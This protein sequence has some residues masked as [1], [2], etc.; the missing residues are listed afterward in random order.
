MKYSRL[1]LYYVKNEYID[2]L[3][4]YDEIVPYNKKMQLDH[5]N[6]YI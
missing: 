3:R 5:D 6:I 1:K 2:Y 4:K